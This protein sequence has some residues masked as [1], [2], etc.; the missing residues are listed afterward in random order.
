MIFVRW[1]A[2]LLIMYFVW[3]GSRLA[4]ITWMFFDAIAWEILGIFV[5]RIAKVM[6]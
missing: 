1:S 4:L 2:N 3:R 6:K 5:Q